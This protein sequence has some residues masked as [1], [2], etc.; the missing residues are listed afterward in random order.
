MQVFR[1][2]NKTFA[3]IKKSIFL[4]ENIGNDSQNVPN[5]QNI[6][7][8]YK[9]NININFIYITIIFITD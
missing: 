2:R 1:V 7:L 9:L 3:K 6:N 8:N 4:N 5:M